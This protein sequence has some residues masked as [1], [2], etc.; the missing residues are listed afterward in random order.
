MEMLTG[1]EQ[2]MSPATV[3][4]LYFLGCSRQGQHLAFQLS[5]VFFFPF[6]LVQDNPKSAGAWVPGLS[7]LACL[8]I[9]EAGHLLIFF[10]F[11]SKFYGQS[12]D[13]GFKKWPK[14]TGTRVVPSGRATTGVAPR[15]LSPQQGKISSLPVTAPR[16]G[17]DFRR[18]WS[19]LSEARKQVPASRGYSK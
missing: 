18:L 4:C 13:P 5:P 19:S 16:G 11:C 14:G 3:T 9:W 10:F 2:R 12:Q 7:F 17:S 6:P 8:C 1:T 15:A